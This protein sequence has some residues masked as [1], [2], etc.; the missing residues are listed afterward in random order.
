M[1]AVFPVFG[2][3]EVLYKEQKKGCDQHQNYN[4]GSCRMG[5][6]LEKGMVREGNDQ[7]E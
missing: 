1:S 5:L 2:K 4:S 3:K 6:S 7:P